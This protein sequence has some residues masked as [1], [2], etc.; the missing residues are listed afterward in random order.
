MYYGWR[1]KVGIVVPH[2]GSAPEHEFHKYLPEGM[3]IFTTRVLFEKVDPKGLDEM[4]RRVLDSAKLLG[5]AGMDIIVF[6]CTTGSLIRGYGYDQQL[7]QEIKEVSGA[8]KA[9]TTS[10]A[11]VRALKAVNA[12]KVIVTTPYSDEV[13]AIEKKFMEDNGFEILDIKGLGYTDPLCMPRVT[14]D[15]MYNLTKQ[16]LEQHPEADTVF[17]SCTGLGII[18][19]VPM[20]EQDF[21]RPVITSNQATWWATLRELGIK[22]DLGL[23]QLFQL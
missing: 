8:K 15:M 2:T 17:V 23:G 10:A 1:G 4:S 13:N 9:M 22:D 11:M 7:I 3:T 18:D 16:V 19:A 6:P 12:K 5:S 21:G 14:P 20:M